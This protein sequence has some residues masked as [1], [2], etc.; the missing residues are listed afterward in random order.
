MGMVVSVYD[1]HGMYAHGYCHCKRS[2]HWLASIQDKVNIK[3]K[4]KIGLEPKVIFLFDARNN[5]VKDVESAI[6]NSPDNDIYVIVSKGGDILDDIIKTTSDTVCKMPKRKNSRKWYVVN[7]RSDRTFDSFIYDEISKISGP[8]A[9]LVIG[10][11]RRIDTEAFRKDFIDRLPPALFVKHNGE[12]FISMR[13]IKE[14]VFKDSEADTLG[15]LVTFGLENLSAYK[16]VKRA[17][18]ASELIYDYSNN[19]NI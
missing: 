16:F 6:N 19:T 9:W 1:D 7:M 12:T 2:S 10:G 14:L 3:Q 11:K 13:I 8:N 17:D 18:N 15:S 4:V 5:T